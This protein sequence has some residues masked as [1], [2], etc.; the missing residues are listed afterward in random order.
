MIGV[1]DGWQP[2]SFSFRPTRFSE[3]RI[4]LFEAESSPAAPKGLSFEFDEE[5]VQFIVCPSRL[6]EVEATA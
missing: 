3:A 5:G 4:V 1:F 2:Q 6:V